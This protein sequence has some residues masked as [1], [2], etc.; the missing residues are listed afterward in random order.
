[1]NPTDAIPWIKDEVA[2][3]TRGWEEF[4]RNRWQHDKV[5][6]STHGVNC[7]GGCCWAIYVFEGTAT[8]EI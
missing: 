5:V 6:R 3:G 7:T 2:P 8:S 4:Y 1:M